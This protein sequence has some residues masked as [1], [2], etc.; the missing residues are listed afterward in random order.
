MAIHGQGIG[1]FTTEN[2]KAVIK[3]IPQSN[4]SYQDVARQV[5]NNGVSLS[6]HTLSRWVKNGRADRR[7]KE[8]QTAYARFSERY[9]ILRSENCKPDDNRDRELDRAL[10]EID[11]ECECGEPRVL[12]PD[13]T[14]GDACRNCLAIDEQ[15]QSRRRTT[16][17]RE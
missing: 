11:R 14:V 8:G 10:M 6:P 3:A 12:M 1:L 15:R 9:D 5:E 7:R 2:I 4:G 17:D 16:R 13:G